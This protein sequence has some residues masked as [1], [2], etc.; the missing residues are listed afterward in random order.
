M[1][2]VLVPMVFALLLIAGCS[3]SA[4]NATDEEIVNDT[5]V[6][7]TAS[8][9]DQPD[10]SD[11]EGSD[12][13]GS[14]VEGTD[15]T[16][17]VED[18]DETPDTDEPEFLSGFDTTGKTCLTDIPEGRIILAT[19]NN[20]TDDTAP[21]RVWVLVLSDDG[22]LIDT[23]KYFDTDKTLEGIGFN[24]NGRLA[25]VSSWDT[26]FVTLFALVG[27]TLCIAETGIVLPNLAE[28][29]RVIFDQITADP[30][31][32]YRFYLTYGNPITTDE[33]SNYSGGIYTMTVDDTGHA[34]ILTDHPAM[35]VPTAFTPLLG[36]MQAVVLGGKE[37]IEDGN[38]LGTAGPDDLAVLD[39]SGQ[40]P[41]VLQWYDIWGTPGAN[42]S[43]P[44]VKSIGVSGNGDYL[45]IANS[46]EYAEDQGLIKLLSNDGWAGTMTTQAE[47]LDATNLDSPDYLVLNNAG[48][49]AVVMNGYFK[50]ATL[51]ITADAITYVKKETHDLTQPMV[52]LHG[53]PFV[54]H[55]LISS[56]R[57]S[58]DESGSIT[59][60]EITADGLVE[61]S[62]TLV[63]LSDSYMLDNLTVQ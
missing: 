49:T 59:I 44:S 18:G 15:D 52:K 5:A 58:N 25:A 7:D 1:K 3:S 16:I 43:G 46:S 19:A 47:F 9:D 54:D 61:V 13:E 20:Y 57:S 17:I 14:E 27:R 62:S 32:P 6:T 41:Q 39:L 48:D 34:T 11:A 55:V 24:A 37:F 38:G 35:H 8:D 60:A 21:W 29:E 45:L 30:R 40:T 2:R 23:G 53:A 28:N 42:G 56:F 26:G 50:G 36:G 63:P 33:Y 12:A 51:G 31:D 10:L 4:S 22:T